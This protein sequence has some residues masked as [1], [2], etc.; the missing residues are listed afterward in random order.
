MLESFMATLFMLGDD[1]ERDVCM[2]LHENAPR[3]KNTC[4]L[5]MHIDLSVCAAAR[6]GSEC[7]Y[8][9]CRLC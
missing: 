8:L 7:L 6:A 1:Y 3:K 5:L 2:E 4:G 9:P